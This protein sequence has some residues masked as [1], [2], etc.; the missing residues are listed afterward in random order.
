MIKL[1]R[2]VRH[3]IHWRCIHYYFLVY[4]ISHSLWARARIAWRWRFEP[5][6]YPHKLPSPLIVS[7]TSYP[8]RFRTL[9]FTL[10]SLLRQT[11]KANR[12]ILWIAH[13][14]MP[15]LPQNV[16]DLQTAGLEIRATG[17][18]KSYKKILPALDAFPNAFIAT[19]DD[20]IY[21]RSTWLEQLVEGV[22]LADRIISCHRA[23]EIIFD[24]EG[25]FKSS[26]AWVPVTRK[27]QQKTLFPHGCGGVL[28]PPGILTHTVE[29]R[30]AALSLCPYNDDLWLYW[31]GRRNG[32]TYK[33]VDHRHKLI[34]W[35]GSQKHC[36]TH[37]NRTGDGDDEQLKNMVEKYGCPQ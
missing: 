24:S 9:A 33:V 14:D 36:L 13:S 6:S 26:R 4:G 25:R 30:A 34:Q 15:L 21:Y 2:Q 11:V 32:A 7:L 19:A 37:Y 29:D 10:R 16:T 28:F 23:N 20:D 18:I 31:I 5:G 22:S 35:F 8:P 17:D 27:K 1:L 12:I 3:S